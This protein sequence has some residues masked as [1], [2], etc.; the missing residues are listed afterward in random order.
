MSE[1]SEAAAGVRGWPRQLR[2]LSPGLVV[3]LIVALAATFVSE[4]Y[5]GPK[6]LYALLM[7][8]ALH[9]LSEDARC[10]PGIEFAARQL[11][12][13]EHATLRYGDAAPVFEGLE[14]SV[15]AGDRI[16]LL[17]PNGAGKSTLVKALAGTMPWSQSPRCRSLPFIGGPALAICAERM[18]ACARSCLPS[19]SWYFSW[20]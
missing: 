18:R 6:F 16:G 7:G 3:A 5:G 4:H 15:L 10:G 8:M 20:L 14:L 2:R 19:A 17:G 13:L 1:I 12:R 9:F 11:V